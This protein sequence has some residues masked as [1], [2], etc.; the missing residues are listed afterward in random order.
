MSSVMNP[1][2]RAPLSR[3]LLAGL[4]TG[5]T[6]GLFATVQTLLSGST[7]TRLWQGVASVPLGPS[8]LEGGTRTALIGVLLHFCTAFWWST[9]FFFLY[10]QSARL[11]GIVQ[12]RF[13]AL[14]VASVYGPLIWIVMSL[15]VIPLFLHRPPTIRPRWW[16]QLIGHIPFVALP[17]VSMIGRRVPAE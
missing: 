1:D 14:K 2:G 17:I 9:V 13:G 15:I 7:V 3:L 10:N 16:V 6:D 5:V 12:S 11:R 8:A 4:L